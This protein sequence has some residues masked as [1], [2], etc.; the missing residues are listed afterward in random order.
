MDDSA[1]LAAKFQVGSALAVEGITAGSAHQRVWADASDELVVSLAGGNAVGPGVS[2]QGIAARPA[3]DRVVAGSAA[4]DVTSAAAFDEVRA[5][6]AEYD[7]VGCRRTEDR[8]RADS[9]A[10]DS[11]VWR[12]PVGEVGI[13]LNI[14]GG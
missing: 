1:P 12:L 8:V 4:D 10:A 14:V 6:A 9:A 3:D 11:A 2:L 13:D 5:R 7:E